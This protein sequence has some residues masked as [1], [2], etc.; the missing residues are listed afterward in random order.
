MF[1]VTSLFYSVNL[2]SLG[3]FASWCVNYAKDVF[4]GQRDIIFKRF[5]LRSTH[6]NV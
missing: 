2:A 6:W 5:L 4:Q 3:I 1:S